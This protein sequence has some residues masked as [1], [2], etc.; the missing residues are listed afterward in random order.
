[1][2]CLPQQLAG[3][4][5]LRRPP[6]RLPARSPRAVKSDQ[7]GSGC[8]SGVTGTGSVRG[9]GSDGSCGAGGRSPGPPGNRGPGS[10]GTGASGSSGGTPGGSGRTP[11]FGTGIGMSRRYPP[12]CG[13]KRA[14]I[15]ERPP[16][17]PTRA[18]PR[19]PAA[20]T[21]RAARPRRPH[22]RPHPRHRPGIIRAAPALGRGRAP[23]TCRR[24]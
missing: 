8:G 16:H 11:A 15:P 5:R 4:D 3:R 13:A 21:P 24:N 9:G 14:R 22:P 23:R 2:S 7:T 20:T 18:H 19:S 17:P 1:L 10:S 12:T 6:R